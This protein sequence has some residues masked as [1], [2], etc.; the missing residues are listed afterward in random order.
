M[1]IS[2]VQIKLPGPGEPAVVL[3][4]AKV[5]L[6]DCL[7][8]HDMRLIQG[9]AG[10][11][12]A[13]P[14]RR[15]MDRCPECTRKNVRRARYCNWCGFLI[16]P[17]LPLQTV[18]RSEMFADVAHPLTAECRREITEAVL[19]AYDGVQAG[20]ESRCIFEAVEVRHG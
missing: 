20:N 10:P 15:L 19:A 2:D 9:A 11:T 5:V 14:S 13:F 17:V 18:P 16:T 8:I 7:V 12:L 1:R 4:Y 3:A 6:D